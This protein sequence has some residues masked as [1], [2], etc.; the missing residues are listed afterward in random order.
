MYNNKEYVCP[1]LMLSIQTLLMIEAS[2]GPKYLYVLNS[3][4]ISN[5]GF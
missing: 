4:D 5:I 2:N 3:N 1:I